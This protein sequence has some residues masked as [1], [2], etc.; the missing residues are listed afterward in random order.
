[1]MLQVTVSP[2]PVS[3]MC[4][5][6]ACP[7]TSTWRSWSTVTASWAMIRPTSSPCP[8]FRTT[9]TTRPP[10]SLALGR[11]R[12]DLHLRPFSLFDARDQRGDVRRGAGPGRT[13]VTP[14]QATRLVQALWNATDDELFGVGPKALPRGTFRMMALG[15]IH[16][17]D[18]RTALQRLVEF[19][20]IATGFEGVEMTEDDRITRLSFDL[21][22]PHPDGS[23]PHR[24]RICAADE[25]Q[26]RD[27]CDHLPDARDRPDRAYVN[28]LRAVDDPLSCC[29]D[30]PSREMSDIR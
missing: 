7:F 28:A 13:R 4:P 26:W 1:V 27:R 11:P 17:P 14:A 30:P 5:L 21:G 10:P 18:L 20:R 3:R 15:V 16:T 9:G 19:T 8:W 24:H 23:V 12:D 2:R 22:G 25:G 6:Y 29:L